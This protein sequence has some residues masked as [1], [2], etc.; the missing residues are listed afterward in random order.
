MDREDIKLITPA[1]LINLPDWFIYHWGLTMLRDV[2]SLPALYALMLSTGQFGLSTEFILGTKGAPLDEGRTMAFRMLKVNPNDATNNANR[3]RKAIFGVNSS[4]SQ[5]PPAQPGLPS[6]A[7]LEIMPLHQIKKLCTR[8]ANR[9]E[10]FTAGILTDN[11][12]RVGRAFVADYNN[13]PAT[14]AAIARMEM[15]DFAV[16]RRVANKQLTNACGYNCAFWALLARAKGNEFDT[17][18]LAEMD[19]VQSYEFIRNM[20]NVLNIFTPVDENP[21]VFL[22]NDHIHTLAAR[23]NPDGAGT[24]AAWLTVSAYNH[25]EAYLDTTIA[26]PSQHGIVHIAIVNT[27]RSSILSNNAEG[28]HWFLAVWI[29]DLQDSATPAAMDM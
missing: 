20:N 26:D 5:L 7:T 24:P 27:I 15:A 17:V 16:T 4:D 8:I 21:G 13:D 22:T 3:V 10:Q 6:P 18:T 2:L 23:F 12:P 29:I 11:A 1:N 19:I 14:L 28:E 9:R 25:W